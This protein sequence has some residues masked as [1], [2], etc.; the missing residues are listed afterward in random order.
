MTEVSPSSSSIGLDE[1]NGVPLGRRY[2]SV[3]ASTFRS[4]QPAEDRSFSPLG[5]KDYDARPNGDPALA[6]IDP[7]LRAV[8]PSSEV[9]TLS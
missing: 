9:I 1:W 3:K 6:A 2:D 8:T 5:P 4:V 7:K